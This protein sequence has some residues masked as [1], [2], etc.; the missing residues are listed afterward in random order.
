[1]ALAKFTPHNA[2]ALYRLNQD[3][4]AKLRKKLEMLEMLD[5]REIS[6]RCSISQIT[7]T[8]D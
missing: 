1:M 3:A 5:S 4:I 7:I 8:T 2:I 6:D